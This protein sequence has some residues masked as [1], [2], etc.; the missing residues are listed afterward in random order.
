MYVHNVCRS[1]GDCCTLY[2]RMVAGHCV[3]HAATVRMQ[4]ASLFAVLLSLSPAAS[5]PLE[6]HGVAYSVLAAIGQV[7]AATVR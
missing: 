5:W 1:N 2:D 3:W 4:D 6:P 7:L